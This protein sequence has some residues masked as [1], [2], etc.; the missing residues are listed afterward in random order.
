MEIFTWQKQ[1]GKPWN[2]VIEKEESEEELQESK[3]KLRKK[4]SVFNPE[5]VS[6]LQGTIALRQP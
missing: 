6:Q 4:I 2:D 5:T 1:A 3:L